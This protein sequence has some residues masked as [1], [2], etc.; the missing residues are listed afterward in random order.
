ML[1][2][3]GLNS[4]VAV[5]A[6]VPPVI[7]G[8]TGNAS[9]PSNIPCSLNGTPGLCVYTSSDTGEGDNN[10][11]FFMDRIRGFFTSDNGKTWVD[12]GDLV[13][14]S[15][16]D[17]SKANGFVPDVSTASGF[18]GPKHVWAPDAIR[19]G[20]TNTYYLYVPDIKDAAAI[21]T[22]GRVGVLR[23]TT[24]PFGS[25]SLLG[26]VKSSAGEPGHMS[27]PDVIRVGTDYWLSWTDGDGANCGVA[28]LQG[29]V[30][31]RLNSDMITYVESTKRGIS[32]SGMKP[33]FGECRSGAGRPYL[34]G[35]SIYDLSNMGNG[36]SISMPGITDDPQQKY[37]MTM[38]AAPAGTPPECAVS[39]G[40]EGTNLQAIAYATSDTV[41]GS[42]GPDGIAGYTY[43]GILFCG[44]SAEWTNHGSLAVLNTWNTPSSKR[45][46]YL[47]HD[48]PSYPHNRKPRVDCVI[49]S[50]GKLLTQHRT[51]EGLSWCMTAWSVVAFSTNGKWV[52]G[53]DATNGGPP[54]GTIQTRADRIGWWEEFQLFNTGTTMRI[55]ART[56]KKWIRINSSNELFADQATV[57]TA[58]DFVLESHPELGDVWYIKI[59][60]NNQY[61]YVRADPSS[62]HL[63]LAGT[64][65]D[66][67]FLFHINTMY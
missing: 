6:V 67:S 34:E 51:N 18:Q 39:L 41:D 35:S 53:E 11:H 7:P 58:A 60:V 3:A 16:L 25:F 42:A 52:T 29:L 1:V 4:S 12:K 40:Y 15:D 64:V 48:G 32:P 36:V 28:G 9:D 49:D 17:K 2:L 63:K 56:N 45:L 47:Y 57:D 26:Y 62:K 38:S 66:S 13:R 8:I 24:G 43:R 50:Y 46:V 23:S 5:A 55:Q 65:P 44:G 22:S 61:Q 10:G 19:V 27:D 31:A 14:E 30:I 33:T 21:N 20:N 37:V 59:L 54:A